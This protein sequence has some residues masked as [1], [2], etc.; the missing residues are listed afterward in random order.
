MQTNHA[1]PIFLI[2]SV[3]YVLLVISLI[4]LVVFLLVSLASKGDERKTH[5]KIKA[6]AN[7]FIVLFGIL[8]LNVIWTIYR[9]VIGQAGSPYPFVY[10]FVVSLVFLIS[11]I[12]NKKKYGD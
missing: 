9:M 6:M 1:S 4:A 7:A 8:L 10:L 2:I 12:I 11:L 5:I 3:V